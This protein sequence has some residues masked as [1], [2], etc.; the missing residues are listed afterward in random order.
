MNTSYL[1]TFIE[2]VNLKNISKAAEKLYITQPAVSKQLQILEKEFET[3]LLKKDGRDMVTT[4]SGRK[5]YKYAVNALN[6]EN[7]IYD[8]IKQNSDVQGEVNIYSSSLPADCF[9]HKIVLEFNKFYSKVTYCI[10]K[11]DSKIVFS[12]IESGLINYGFVGTV[13]KKGKLKFITI[14]D[15]ELVIAASNKSFSQYKNQS[16][17]ID[18]IFEHNFISRENGSATLRTLENYLNSRN[19][20]LDDL[21]IKVKV[22]DNEIIKT[23]VKNDMGIAIISKNAIQKEIKE[24]TIIPIKL[25]DVELKRKIYFVYHSGRYFSR[26]EESFKNFI[27][28]NYQI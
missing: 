20:C 4:E 16:V 2:V 9:L 13:F 23:L 26:I 28:D 3:V 10:N 14:A 27:I 11:V 17:P 8:K 25:K 6:A 7:H 15:D 24:G 18:F 1:K 22:E 21:K 12:N 19:L 5:L